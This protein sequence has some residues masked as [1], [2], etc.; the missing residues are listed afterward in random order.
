ML[1]RKDGSLVLL[2]FGISMAATVDNTVNYLARPG[3][4]FKEDDNNR[5][6]DDVYSFLKMLDSLGVDEEL[7]HTAPYKNGSFDRQIFKNN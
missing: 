3:T 4:F 7:K 2:D 1:Q 6:Y 5:E